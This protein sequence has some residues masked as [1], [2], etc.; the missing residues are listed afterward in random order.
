[1]DRLRLRGEALEHERVVLEPPDELHDVQVAAEREVAERALVRVVPL[2]EEDELG[3]HV[4]EQPLEGE[5]DP[6][7]R[8]QQAA[9]QLARLGVREIDP[10]FVQVAGDGGQGL[11]ADVDA[12]EREPP[13]VV[14]LAHSLE[15]RLALAPRLVLEELGCQVVLEPTNRRTPNSSR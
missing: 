8:R 2:V 12:A 9:Q 7:R 3:L 15:Q 14:R 13:Q 10:A 4:V 11:P 5:Q 6:H 1:M